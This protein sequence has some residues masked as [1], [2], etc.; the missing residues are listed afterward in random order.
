MLKFIVTFALK[1]CGMSDKTEIMQKKSKNNLRYWFIST[2]IVFF[3][4]FLLEITGTPYVKLK[5]HITRT[6]K[7]LYINLILL[8][9]FIFHQMAGYFRDHSCTQ[10]W[11]SFGKQLRWTPMFRPQSDKTAQVSAEKVALLSASSFCGDRHSADCARSYRYP[12]R[13]ASDC[14]AE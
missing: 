2:S 13:S 6:F 1:G 5:C 7:G 4:Y 11:N 10:S 9:Q 8:P 3:V 14:S 12:S